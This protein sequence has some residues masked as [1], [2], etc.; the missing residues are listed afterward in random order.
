M[1][2]PVFHFCETPHG[3]VPRAAELYVLNLSKLI[4]V[5]LHV[6]AISLDKPLTWVI[7][8]KKLYVPNSKS[9]HS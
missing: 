8:V 9:H 5:M 1:L 7:S 4:F 3:T 6:Y 2:E